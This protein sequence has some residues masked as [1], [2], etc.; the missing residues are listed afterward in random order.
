MSAAACTALVPP[1]P[2]LG[3]SWKASIEGNS[4]PVT[5]A[6][7]SFSFGLS[8]RQVVTLLRSAA[9]TSGALEVRPC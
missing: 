2:C 6:F 9:T 8:P 3:P 4:R 5:R 7:W 1:P